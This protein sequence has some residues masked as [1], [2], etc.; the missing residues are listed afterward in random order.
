MAGSQRASFLVIAFAPE[1]TTAAG[2]CS[3]GFRI[4]LDGFAK[5]SDGEVV[6]ALLQM[7][8]CSFVIGGSVVRV[9]PNGRIEVSEGQI[10][11]VSG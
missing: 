11:L 8:A 3:R 5:V 1:R 4:E 10:G 6:L 9:D 2:Q 7:N